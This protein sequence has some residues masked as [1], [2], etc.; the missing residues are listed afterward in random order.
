[1]ITA[2]GLVI[3]GDIAIGSEGTEVSVIIGYPWESF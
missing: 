2:S 1:M 3:R